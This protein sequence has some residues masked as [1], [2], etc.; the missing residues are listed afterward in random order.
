MGRRRKNYLIQ[1]LEDEQFHDAGRRVILPGQ[2]HRL[3]ATCMT[4]VGG[5]RE[6]AEIVRISAG[7]GTV[8][9][10]DA[11]VAL[12]DDA[13]V[14][15]ESLRLAGLGSQRG[16]TCLTS[17]VLH[18]LR[19]WLAQPYHH[20]ERAKTISKAISEASW[21][22]IAVVP[23][24]CPMRPA[25]LGYMRLIGLRRFLAIPGRDGRTMLATAAED[26]CQTMN[27]I[28]QK[29]GPRALGLAKKGRIDRER[30]R[31]VNLNDEMQCLHAIRHSL[32]TGREV[33]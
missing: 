12:N 11:N 22:Q 13:E 6:I 24:D 14:V 8:W 23:A 15:W 9:F 20:V 32:L 33:W 17:I 1:H 25:L 21:A 4:S 27:A 26:K 3:T 28:D 5:W 2:E 18:E 29:I 10:P 19:D 30:Y 16:S 31:E 7:F